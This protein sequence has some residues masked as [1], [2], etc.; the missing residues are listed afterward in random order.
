MTCWLAGAGGSNSS[1][2]GNHSDNGLNEHIHVQYASTTFPFV[3][4]YDV[5]IVTFLVPLF[6]RRPPHWLTA[7]IEIDKGW[8]GC[9]SVSSWGVVAAPPCWIKITQ[10]KKRPRNAVKEEL[11]TQCGAP[12]L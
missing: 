9:C 12:F 8:P 2:S 7:N 10:Q 11:Q 4:D 5:H 6:V 1:I 3:V